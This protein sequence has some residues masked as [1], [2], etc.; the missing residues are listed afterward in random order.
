MTLHETCAGAGTRG[1]GAPMQLTAAIFDLDGTLV[2]SA[3]DILRLLQASLGAEGVAI[4][5]DRL[6]PR[7]LGPPLEEIVDA[8]SPGLDAGVKARVVLRYRA[9]YRECAFNESPLYPH[10]R[11]QL[12]ELR[13]AGLRL[14][15]ATYKPR[16]VSRRL[17][18]HHGI[19]DFFEATIHSDSSP[20]GRLSKADML[21]QLVRE[22]GLSP[23]TTLMQGDG[24]GDMAAARANG[25][26]AAAALYGYGGRE[27]LLAA[28][29]DVC[30]QS[31]DWRTGAFC[32]D[33]SP[34]CW[35]TTVNTGGE[36]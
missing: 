10:V 4:P 17:L 32:A 29:P 1:A 11:A 35:Q 18:Q 7:L 22:Y 33:G 9:A 13:G 24:T 16:D 30:L 3:G 28:G 14:F 15:V 31:P 34:F 8:L 5:P 25:I 20:A 26:F 6:A 19:L 12:E 36:A 21:C 23:A 27:G 2:A